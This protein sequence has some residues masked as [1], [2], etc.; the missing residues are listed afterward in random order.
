MPHQ[1]AEVKRS[2]GI[3]QVTV[4]IT[5]R[6][7]LKNKIKSPQEH[8]SFSRNS[9]NVLAGV[10]QEVMDGKHHVFMLGECM[11]RITNES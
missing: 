8:F 2:N 3:A 1:A 11:L 6:F 5:R 7:V 4:V 9:K 10:Q